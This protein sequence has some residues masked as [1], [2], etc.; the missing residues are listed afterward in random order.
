MLAKYNKKD[1]NA[2]L[3]N[4]LA[5]AAGY[6][7]RKV[8]DALS[9]QVL[10]YTNNQMFGG[11]GA[12]G[13]RLQSSGGSIRAMKMVPPKGSKRGKR[14]KKSAK[15]EPIPRAFNDSRIRVCLRDVISVTNT[16][17]NTAAGFYQLACSFTAA[18]D[19]RTWCPRAGTTLAGAFRYFKVCK[20][21]FSFQPQLPYTSSGTMVLGVDPDPNAPSPT[22][23]TDVYKHP[24][25]IMGDI[26]D[27]HSL[28][29]IPGNNA[30]N[31]DKLTNS[32]GVVSAPLEISE[33]T[34]QYF[35]LNSEIS[36][37]VLGNFLVELEVEYYG[38]Q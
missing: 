34:V 9:K 7:S 35:S 28:V 33:G 21:T 19:M 25:S 22:N 6:G 31:I 38:L 4:S 13:P 12:S 36:G 11:H 20:V 17:A 3:L 23:S 10:D 1:I 32:A 24:A 8:V 2:A 26:K 5:A 15:T 18:R 27:A 37:A 16:A 30:Q 29:W 14:G